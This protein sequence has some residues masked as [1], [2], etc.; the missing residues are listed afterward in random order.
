MITM[1]YINFWSDFP[2]PCDYKPAL[3]PPYS[4]RYHAI[5]YVDQVSALEPL[6]NSR[7]PSSAVVV[8]NHVNKN[9]HGPEFCKFINLKV[10]GR[11]PRFPFRSKDILLR[12][13]P[14]CV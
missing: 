9:Q 8:T 11:C 6:V 2:S 14:T 10:C 13:M 4:S 7:A 1:A 12:N 5:D 3:Q